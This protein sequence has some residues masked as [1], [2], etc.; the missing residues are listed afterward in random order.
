MFRDY[1]P[2]TGRYIQSD[3]IGL[4]AGM[5]TY[6]YVRQNP[7]TYFDPYGLDT[8][9]INRDLS[10]FGNQPEPRTD[11]WTHTFVVTTNPDGS[12][13]HTYSWGNS[14]N[15]RSWNLDQPLDINTAQQALKNGWA[16]KAG[17][18]DLDPFIWTAF[19]DVNTPEN[20]H[21]NLFIIKNC[22]TEA[23]NLLELAW[24]LHDSDP[25]MMQKP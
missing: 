20:Q 11:A 14:S 9:V 5:N 8:Y 17:N 15:P 23:G 19:N 21:Q 13:S 18:S 4:A 12:I 1:D 3:P 10:F 16:Q 24:K 7:L 25:I 2:S 6:G 22:K